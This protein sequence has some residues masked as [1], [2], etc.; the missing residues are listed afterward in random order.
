MRAIANV[1][2]PNMTDILLRPNA[3]K[4]EVL[5]EFLHGTQYKAG[6]ID[7]LGLQGSEIQVKEFMLNHQ[8]LLGISEH[9]L[10]PSYVDCLAKGNHDNF[11]ETIPNESCADL[12]IWL[13]QNCFCWSS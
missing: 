4:I 7:R 3:T 5:E 11:S 1:G 10:R 13:G 2:G 6:I 8:R 9:K 12:Q